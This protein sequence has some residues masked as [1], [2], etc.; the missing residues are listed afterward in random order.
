[1][2]NARV[3]WDGAP[4]KGWIKGGS[5]RRAFGSEVEKAK[6]TQIE[7]E[8]ANPKGRYPSNIVG[9]LDNPEHQKYFYAPRATRKERGEYNDHPTPKPINLMRYLVRIY[10]PKNGIVLDPYMGSGSTGIG[11]I[12]E[13]RNFVGV[14][15]NQHY[16]DI[17]QKRIQEHCEDT[18]FEKLFDYE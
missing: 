8:D 17:A 18:N 11:A 13:Q 16:V 12:Q 4:P 2:D 15:S 6:G 5:K 3:P 9:V 1:M 10:T 14:D 7:K